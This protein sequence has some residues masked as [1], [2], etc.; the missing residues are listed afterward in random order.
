MLDLFHG[1]IIANISKVKTMVISRAHA[2]AVTGL[3]VIS[4]SS[5]HNNILI[6]ST[7]IDQRVK[8]WEMTND[9]RMPGVD[10]ISLKRRR[11]EFTAVADVSSMALLEGTERPS[12][13]VCGVG[14]DVWRHDD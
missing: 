2:A 11:N 6:A 10:G 9:F 1:S 5:N 4:S 13:V 3:E 8:M 7:S 12:I 14:M